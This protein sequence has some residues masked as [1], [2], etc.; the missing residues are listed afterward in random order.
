MKILVIDEDKKKAA[1][2]FK[3][4]LKDREYS[5]DLAS[6]L[7]HTKTFFHKEKYN[8]IIIDFAT[9]D[10]RQSLDYILNID[11]NQKIITQSGISECSELNGCDYCIEHYNKRRLVKQCSANDILNIIDKFDTFSCYYANSFKG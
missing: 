10:G 1:D 4:F 11:A 8:I 7:D 6:T 5:I 3:T 9:K 2:I